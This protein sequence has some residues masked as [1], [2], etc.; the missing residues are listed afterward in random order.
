MVTVAAALVR[1]PGLA[2]PLWLDEA[3]G[4]VAATATHPLHLLATTDLHP[5]LLLVLQRLAT[6]VGTADLFVRLPSWLAAVATVP[7]AWSLGRAFGGRGLDLAV[8]AAFAPPLVAVGAQ[9][10][11]YALAVWL[12][13]LTVDAALRD[14]A[15]RLTLAAPAATASVY[16][17]WP[18]AAL[19]AGVVAWRRRT[20]AGALPL[21]A[22]VAMAGMLGAWLVPLQRAHQGA[23]L[24]DGFLAPWFWTPSTLGAWLPAL[25]RL[26]GY[27]VTGRASTLSLA[28]GVPL[29]LGVAGLLPRARADARL[30]LAWG[31]LAGLGVAAG[32]GLHPLGPTRHALVLVLPLVGWVLGRRTWPTTTPAVLAAA[33]LLALPGAPRPPVERVTA[34]VA[35]LPAVPRVADASAAPAL[36][37]YGAHVVATLPWVTGPRLDEAL[38]DAIPAGPACVVF[39]STRPEAPEAVATWASVRGRE[40][41]TRRAQAGAAAVCVGPGPGEVPHP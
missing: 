18:V 23:G 6:L 8:V 5:P 11:P 22:T 38:D 33:L 14:D 15:R 29:L 30:L 32:L 27:V 13:V 37:W 3:L 4:A 26:A 19:A 1:L 2:P 21:V 34:L 20:V 28:V 35:T 39:G 16:G 7:A 40:V 17:A 12:T 41:T 9:A 10:R 24:T 31:P 25:P 36:A